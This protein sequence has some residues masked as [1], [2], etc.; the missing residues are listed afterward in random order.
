MS[1]GTRTGRLS[2][3]V[4]GLDDILYG[5]FPAGRIFLVYGDAGT[6]KTTLGL[7]FLMAGAAAGRRCLCI[8]LL[9]TLAELHDVVASHRWETNG[10]V[11]T[12]LPPEIREAATIG[13][14]V[15]TTAD[16]ELSEVTDAIAAAVSEHEPECLFIDSVSELGVLVETGYPMRRQL[17]KLKQLLDSINCT[18][19]LSSRLAG[20]LDDGTLETLVHGIIGLEMMAPDFGRPH[21]RV[22]V[23]KMRG[24]DFQGGYHDADIRTGGLQVYPRVLAGGPRTGTRDSVPSGNAGIDYLLGGGMEEGTTCVIAGTSGA[25]KSTLSS[26]YA[27]AAA[28]RGVGT[29]MFC[30]DERIETLL[31]RS[32]ALGMPLDK[33]IDAGTV[34]IHQINV[35]DVSPGYL[36]HMVRRAVE[37]DGVRIVVLD[38]L[39]AYLGSMPGQRELTSQL[40]EL[41]GYLSSVGVLCIMV[42]ASHGLFGEVRSPIDVS[43]I[44]D[45][46]IVLRAFES[47]GEVRRCIAVLKKRYG[48]HDHMIR[49]IQLGPGGIR[50]GDPLVSFSGVLTGLPRYTG[51]ASRLMQADGPAAGGQEND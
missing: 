32:A 23:T 4:E 22:L 37:R 27:F 20:G 29:A 30:F 16:V 50:V 43:Y 21:R 15:F 34:R 17:L 1:E 18:T 42:I 9:Q 5:G 41:L 12:E 46:V 31:H 25:G 39:S 44:A 35:S 19:L 3:G 24:M 26:L 33:H 48:D 2:S 36:A 51:G 10:I 28:G 49:E 45:T 13:Q 11:M 14:T 8:T 47:F 40:H 7:Q 38:S 6:G